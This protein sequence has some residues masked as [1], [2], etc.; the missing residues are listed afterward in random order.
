MWC[1][2][3]RD[4][5]IQALVFPLVLL[6]FPVG[7]SAQQ[8]HVVEDQEEDEVYVQFLVRKAREG[9]VPERVLAMEKMSEIGFSTLLSPLT[10]ALSNPDTRLRMTAVQAIGRMPQ[11]QAISLLKNALFDEHHM[12]GTAALEKVMERPPDE[13]MPLLIDGLSHSNER[14]RSLCHTRLRRWTGYRFGYAPSSEPGKRGE[15]VDRWRTWW[16]KNKDRS[17]EEWWLNRLR[18]VKDHPVDVAPIVGAMG[19]LIQR[20]SWSAVPRLIRLLDHARM[21]VRV[22]AL[23]GLRTITQQRFDFTP[24][25][26]GEVAGRVREE[27]RSWWKGAGA[28]DRVEWLVSHLKTLVNKEE[29]GRRRERVERIISE[30]VGRTGKTRFRKWPPCS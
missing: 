9:T 8:D 24:D 21:P 15:A 1:S 23:D 25:P 30:L 3:K 13:F 17:P 20:K 28:T 11:P 4:V 7:L 6:F 27:W 16:T 5:V 29:T 22:N 19:Q 14:V 10:D 2:E 18:N 12:T 26:P